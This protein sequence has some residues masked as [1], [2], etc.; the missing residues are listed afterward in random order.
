[1]GLF[2]K[3]TEK[4]NCDICGKSDNKILMQTLTDGRICCDCYKKLDKS[5][6][7]QLSLEEARRQINSNKGSVKNTSRKLPPEFAIT[8]KNAKKLKTD[9]LE[10]S[11]P[12]PTDAKTAMYRGR[13]FSIS[14]KSKNF[15]KLPDDILDTEIDL[16]PFIWKISKP[17]YCKPGTEIKFS[18]RPFEDDRSPEEIEEYMIQ[19]Q[20][21]LEKE[22]NRKDYNWICKKLPEISPKSLSG[23]TRMK[24]SNSK[25]Y[26][27]I[28]IAAREKGYII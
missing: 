28:V 8:I 9:L 24:N 15:P 25:N 10:A 2:N 12:A 13:I 21:Q 4:Y 5:F 23:Y 26:Q 20:E 3:L 11:F 18:N 16:Y 22:K 1:M 7:Q 17:L 14:G 19:Q 27:K 6:F